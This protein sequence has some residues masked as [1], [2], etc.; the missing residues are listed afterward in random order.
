V[1]DQ[2]IGR[3]LA[4]LNI[5]QHKFAVLPPW[6]GVRGA[7][8]GVSFCVF[9]Y[10]VFPFLYVMPLTSS[11]TCF[12]ILQEAINKLMEIVYPISDGIPRPLIGVLLKYLAVLCLHHDS[13]IEVVSGAS[14]QGFIPG[15]NSL[16][17]IPLES[18][19]RTVGYGFFTDKAFKND[20]VIGI[21]PHVD[22]LVSMDHLLKEQQSLGDLVKTEHTYLLKSI[23]DALDEG[24]S[25]NVI[26]SNQVR[27]LLPQFTSTMI[28]RLGERGGG[29]DEEEGIPYET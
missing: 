25:G 23:V 9:V 8:D 12:D 27:T 1:G 24:V 3:I 19:T 15:Y 4:D 17:R 21:R 10:L 14:G 18:E 6:L 11:P 26:S 5:H 22:Q 13:I 29:G 28:D 7:A 20:V 2:F 16:F